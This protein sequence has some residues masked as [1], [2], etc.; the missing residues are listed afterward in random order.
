MILVVL[1][2]DFGVKAET[3]IAQVEMP[4]FNVP[5]EVVSKF[6]ANR[7]V[8][9]VSR[10]LEEL[11]INSVSFNYPALGKRNIESQPI[12]HDLLTDPARKLRIVGG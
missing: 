11:G 3:Q 6:R 8:T 10:R 9:A 12:H 1:I 4:A 7:P 5:S 2:S